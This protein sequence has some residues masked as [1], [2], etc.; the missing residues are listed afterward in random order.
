[1]R[2][3][4]IQAVEGVLNRPISVAEAQNIE[5]TIL[6]NMR[7]LNRQDTTAW[8]AM[9]RDQRLIA[10]AQ[11]A[12]R[13]LREAAY[14]KRRVA[15][16]AIEAHDRNVTF[17]NTA[18]GQ[19]LEGLDAVERLVAFKPD[20]RSDVLSLETESRAVRANAVRQLVDTFTAVSP[21]FF[22]LF[23][24]KEGVTKLTKALFGQPSG[25]ARIDAGARAWLDTA[26]MLRTQFNELGGK[27]RELEDWAIP[28]HH[29]QA[30]VSNAARSSDPM[31]NRDKW[32]QDTMPL[33][34]RGRY[35][36]PEGGPMNPAEMTDF[37]NHAWETL[38]TGGINKL[39]PG[40]PKG[41]GMLANRNS[42]ARSIHFRDADAYLEYQQLYGERDLW[43]IMTGHVDNLS[44]QIAQLKVFGPN[45]DAGLNAL[46]DG[47][48]QRAAMRDPASTPALEARAKRV[49]DL[50]NFFTGNVAPIASRKLAENFDTIRS[51]N[52]ASRLG[53]SVITAFFTDP[54][55]I[56]LTAQA[57]N[58]SSFRLWRNQFGNLNPFNRADRNL[59]HRAG[60]AL[61]VMLGELNRWGADNLGAEAST[62]RARASSKVASTV[63]RLSLLPALDSANRRAF[64]ATMMHALGEMV[65]KHADLSAV[66]P[67]DNRILLSK[68]IT[69]TDFAVWKLAQLEHWGRGN[70]VLTPEGI[71]QISDTALDPLVQIEAANLQ[72]ELQQKINN[73]QNNRAL[74]PQQ[75]A[76]SVADLTRLYGERIAG[77]G[78]KIRTDAMHRLL[79]V[80]LEESDMAVINPGLSD[81]FTTGGKNERGTW[82]GEL[83]RSIWQ[84]KGFPMAMI[85]RHMGRGL[86]APTAGGKAY[87]IA[88]LVVGTWLL[89]ILAQT[90]NDLLNGKDVRNYNPA[91]QYG[92]QNNIAALL[93][94]G[95]L[96]LYGDF[97]FSGTT[98]TSRT[99]PVASALGPVAGL[100]EE[101]F[102]LTQG[103]IVQAI[104]GEDTNFGAE[105]T[106]WVKG[107]TPGASLWYSK[108][109]L[110]HL[111]FQQ[112]QEAMNPGYL[113]KMERRLQQET[114]QEYW[115]EPGTGPEG[116]QA[117]QPERALGEGQ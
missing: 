3:R 28:Q 115:W 90:V 99:G 42:E 25:D 56:N 71:A 58:L 14:Q 11:G 94:G 13:E 65:N 17:I 57:N 117:P 95:A 62:R 49:R 70:K 69:A 55:T 78:Q 1:M 88:K 36:T 67:I 105:A 43:S 72:V 41:S 64:G 10:A 40:G 26:E 108:A 21:K 60:L 24:N 34:D 114:G 35:Y 54:A 92:V 12:A 93:K 45:A 79:G 74:M 5:A 86:S 47:E 9:T 23:E 116:M 76:D 112:M 80:T 75:I 68:G 53:S 46:L 85:F 4:C 44:K 22:G 102:N 27:I 96:G 19:G 29:S 20:G 61:D 15:S 39:K 104:K 63:M 84:F 101:T 97:L 18:R 51:W 50:Y 83:G 89:G 31:A 16:L 73:V 66:D 81:R 113:R 48:L 82:S 110:D 77:L 38:A 6:R 111:I 87:Y 103:N 32:V 30:K 52:V 107:N 8:N 59:A 7:A 37:L 106:R 2:Q 109:I 91:E 98:Q 100:A 33:L